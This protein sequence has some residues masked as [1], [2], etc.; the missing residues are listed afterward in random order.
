MALVT[1]RGAR[2]ERK[3]RAAEKRKVW[4][5]KTI[6]VFRK[7]F[8]GQKKSEDEDGVSVGSGEEESRDGRIP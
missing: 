4:G 3:A 1:E 6:D 5:A 7:A 8:A 2:A